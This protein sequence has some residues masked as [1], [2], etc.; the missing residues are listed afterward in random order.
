MIETIFIKKKLYSRRFTSYSKGPNKIV[1]V[2]LT[3]L[4]NPMDCL[5]I[6]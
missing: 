1:V 3:F 2:K 6:L 4:P 5:S